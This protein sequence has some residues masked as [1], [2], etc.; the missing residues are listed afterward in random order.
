MLRK[1]HVITIMALLF[2][3]ITTGCGEYQK[4]L[5]SSDFEYK[6]KK[7]KEY[8]AEG[9][10]V[11]ACELFRELV[12][13]YRGTSKADEIY[14][15]Y[16]QSYYESG[17]YLLAGHWYRTLVTEYPRSNYRKDAQYM[18]A[19]CYYD[20]SPS[21]R[22]DQTVTKKAIDAYQLYVNLFPASDKVSEANEKID[23][24]HDKLV[25]KSFLT[26]KLYYDLENYKASTIALQNSLKE[27]PN[28]SYREE[29]KFMLLRSKYN[30]G[31]RSVE[32]LQE[33]RLSSALDEYFTFVDEYPESKHR[34]AADKYYAELSTRLDYN[35]EI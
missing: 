13:V 10:Y 22:L 21:I 9:E 2:L 27:F 34:K 16:A 4:V 3:L 1:T 23:E 29:L 20:E 28:S 14:Y 5:K 18:V 25:Y 30:L 24:L 33:E 8:Y 17:D 26:A 7:A 35:N 11:R 15:N 19:R 6:Y 32:E 31:V 12:T